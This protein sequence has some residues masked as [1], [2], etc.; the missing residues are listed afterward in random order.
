MLYSALV[1]QD[2]RRRHHGKSTT[3]LCFI[4]C[5][6]CCWSRWK[7]SK[8]NN[9]G[10]STSIQ[11]MRVQYFMTCHY[12]W[13]RIWMAGVPSGYP[14]CSFCLPEHRGLETFSKD[15]YTVPI[16]IGCCA[17]CGRVCTC[18]TY[19][20]CCVILAPLIAKRWKA[21]RWSTLL[22]DSESSGPFS[23]WSNDSTWF[24]H[25]TLTL[26]VRMNPYDL[27]LTQTNNSYQESPYTDTPCIMGYNG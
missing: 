6:G 15:L 8:R 3:K 23:I 4:W 18:H 22:L 7:T 26:Y 5:V 1:G 25:L 16:D 21:D 10:R 12:P 14:L 13:I 20:H 11:T 2:P 9:G 17:W 27:S 24:N 19:P